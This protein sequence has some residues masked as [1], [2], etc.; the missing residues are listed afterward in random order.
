MKYSAIMTLSRSNTYMTASLNS[1][2]C[3]EPDEFI[4][5][6]EHDL[7]KNNFVREVLKDSNATMKPMLI[8]PKMEQIHHMVN[9]A[10]TTYHAIAKAKHEWVRWCD[11]DDQWVNDTR[12][13]IEEYGEE[14]VGL[15]HGDV[16]FVFYPRKGSQMEGPHNIKN[17]FIG[18]GNIINRDAFRSVLAPALRSIHV[19][20]AAFLDWRIAYWILRGGWNSVYVPQV[21][22]TQGWDVTSNQQSNPVFVTRRQKWKNHWEHIVKLLDEYPIREYR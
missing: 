3:Q 21:F 7:L 16:D 17:K 2:R 10:I 20:E 18:S 19:C 1:I 9:V 12:A 22:C 8:D 15:I 11:D 14:L 6:V 5:Y 4:V 13:I